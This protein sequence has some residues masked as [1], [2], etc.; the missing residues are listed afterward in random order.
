MPDPISVELDTFSPNDP[1]DVIETK[2][3]ALANKLPQ[4][5]TQVN[6]AT[7]AMNFNSTN[8]SSST[9]WTVADSG[10]QTFGI[11]ADK[12]YVKGMTVKVASS[13]SPQNWGL[14]DVTATTEFTVTVAFRQKNGS[15]TFSSWTI[16]QN[17]EV[18][19][20]W[21]SRSARTSNNQITSAD[22]GRLLDITSGTFDQTF[23]P[24]GDLGDGFNVTI[25]NS[26]TGDVTLNPDGSETID[27][28]TSFIMY[29][30][31]MREIFCD[32][33]ALYSVVLN[34]FYRR[35]TSTYAN[36]PIPPGY[37]RFGIRAWSGGSSGQRT[38]NAATVSRGGAGG[39]C[40]DAVLPAS[41]FGSTETVTIG[42]GGAAITTVANGNVGGD[43]SF[44]SLL[45]VYAGNTWTQGG[46][47]ID[48]FFESA[49]N[50]TE[51]VYA[52]DQGSNAVPKTGI[53]GGS[54]SSANATNDSGDAL[55][56]GA[57]GGSL[58]GS[59]TLRA[60]GSSTFGGNGGAASSASN[61]TAGSQ[62]GGGG[63]ATQT[64]TQSGAGGSGQ[65]DFWG[66]A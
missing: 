27:G 56:A 66:I 4:L 31:E 10:S 64:G 16:S 60:A 42:A 55:Y 45:T 1:A 30:G 6:A 34:P 43:T 47:A 59:A 24:V 36:M 15:G 62:P 14:G 21:R 53:F 5:A 39:G 20:R 22:L 52:G 35:I 54:S 61:G 51:A 11:P 32:G 29:P 28:R 37:T 25:R 46:S 19:S 44:G 48:G 12:S 8:A 41:D 26:G 40:V 9:S 63:G 2:A 3:T 13:A 58:D 7:K 65:V 57:A 38:N 50:G 17:A 18:S 49:T 33:T 23:D